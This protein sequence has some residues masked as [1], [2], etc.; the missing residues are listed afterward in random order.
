MKYTER[1]PNC[2]SLMQL[3]GFNSQG[4]RVTTC[5]A[6][7]MTKDAETGEVSSVECNMKKDLFVLGQKVLHVNWHK[8]DKP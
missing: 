2:A 3:V 7:L 5:T 6:S 4:L 1:C 8:R